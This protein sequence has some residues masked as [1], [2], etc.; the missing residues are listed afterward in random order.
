M[1][2]LKHAELIDGI[3]HTPSQVRRK[4]S[5][6]HPALIAWITIYSEA[7]PGCRPD[8]E[9]TWLMQDDAPQPDASLLI[10]PEYGGQSSEQDIYSAG[11]PELV[12]ELSASSR[13]YHLG[14][15]LRLYQSSGVREYVTMLLNQR[16]IIWRELADGRYHHIAAA[17]GGIHKSGV[18]PG[19]WLNLAAFW[20]NDLTTLF[21]T[22]RQGLDTP[23]HAAFVAQLA[24]RRKPAT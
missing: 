22:L 10:L 8:V 14:A 3:V 21:A 19:L 5:R 20:D 4:H 6:Y 7:T 1:P 17:A 9:G 12:I 18:F 11:A 2:H 23:G 24:A 15:K 13:S 16:R